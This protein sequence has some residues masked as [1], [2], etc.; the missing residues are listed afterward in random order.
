MFKSHLAE[1]PFLSR[2]VMET[3]LFVRGNLWGLAL[4]VL[5]LGFVAQYIFRQPKLRSAAL[6]F[7]L[8]LPVI[9]AWLTES[10][11]EP[12]VFARNVEVSRH[13]FYPASCFLSVISDGTAV[14]DSDGSAVFHI[15]QDTLRRV[16]V[17]VRDASASVDDSSSGSSSSRA[18][19]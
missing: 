12:G 16:D 4:A 13:D 6:D 19:S 17:L 5:V 9:G 2:M 3:G 14:S 1:L 15:P 11:Q 18:S 8:S 7:G 10:E